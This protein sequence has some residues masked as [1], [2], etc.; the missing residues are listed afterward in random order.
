MFESQKLQ[1]DNKLNNQ[2]KFMHLDLENQLI[3][4]LALQIP[5]FKK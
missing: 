1:M 2:K 3:S 5:F 4:I